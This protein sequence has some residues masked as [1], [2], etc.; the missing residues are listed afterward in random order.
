MIFLFVKEVYY[1]KKDSGLTYAGF[2]DSQ[3]GYAMSN[4]GIDWNQEAVKATKQYAEY[5]YS[6]KR[7]IQNLEDD[8]FTTSQINY[9]ISNSGVNW[10]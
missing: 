8:G 2:T 4:C 6:K 9:G 3:I 7:V 10:G 1:E 5:G